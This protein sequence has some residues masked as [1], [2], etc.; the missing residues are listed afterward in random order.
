M[1]LPPLDL[2]RLQRAALVAIVF[3]AVSLPWSTSATAIAV[4]IWL[5]LLVPTLT[6]ADLRREMTTPEAALPVLLVALGV[7][8]IFWSEAGLKGSIGGINS[9]VKLLAIPF[10]FVQFRRNRGGSMVLAGYLAS[11]AMLLLTSYLFV[12]W[13]RLDL[14]PDFPRP[15][16][17]FNHELGVPVKDYIAQSGEFIFAICA[18]LWLC[19]RWTTSGRY[20]LAVFGAC[21]MGAFLANIGYVITAKTS[22]VVLPILFVVFGLRFLRPQAALLLF[23]AGAAVAVVLWMSSSYL[24][25]RVEAVLPEI[26]GYFTH[27]TVSSSA[28]RLEYWK[29]AFEFAREAPFIGHGTGSI[30]A[31][32]RQAVSG[33]GLS[34]EVTTNPHNQTAAVAIQLGL[35]GVALLWGMW[36][37]HLWMFRGPSLAA[38]A[39]FIVATQNIVGSA[40][41]SHLFDFTQGWTYV[42]G[43]GVAGG[44]IQ[45]LRSEAVAGKAAPAQPV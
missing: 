28:E 23:I 36:L 31:L 39:G 40:F 37:V 25:V 24:R 45:R 22:L 32:Y 9:F 18:L 41:N 8:G 16:F 14:P 15:R 19:L 17:L 27:E 38:W 43:V 5:C 42:V 33:T 20:A 12:L 13:R 35:A 44:V 34:A 7:A 3:V 29:K 30:P 21:A 1:R 4:P 10:L 26:R 11:C 6:W 2:D